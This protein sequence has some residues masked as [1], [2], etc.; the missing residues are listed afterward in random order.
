VCI[1]LVYIMPGVN[2]AMPESL[3]AWIHENGRSIDSYAPAVLC[4]G[5]HEAG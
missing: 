4:C 1:T 2:P 3:S 5:L